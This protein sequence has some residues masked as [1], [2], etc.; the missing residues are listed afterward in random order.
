MQTT[1]FA[2]PSFSLQ[3]CMEM[4]TS[5][6][7]QTTQDLL[8]DQ[9]CANAAG[10]PLDEAW[11]VSLFMGLGQKGWMCRVPEAEKQLKFP[12]DLREI[13]ATARGV[14]ASHVLLCD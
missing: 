12:D 3:N 10:M 2:A 5:K 11:D 9:G 1:H 7:S 4:P 13:F 14:G 6:V 8:T